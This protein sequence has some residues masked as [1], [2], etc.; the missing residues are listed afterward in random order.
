MYTTNFEQSYQPVI[1][2]KSTVIDRPPDEKP[3]DR[4]KILSRL[5]KAARLCNLLIKGKRVPGFHPG[6]DLSNKEKEGLKVGMTN[7]SFAFSNLFHWPRTIDFQVECLCDCKI[8]V[9]CL[10]AIGIHTLW[11]IVSSTGDDY[12]GGLSMAEHVFG[13]ERQ[14]HMLALVEKPTVES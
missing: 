1:T 6:R 9:G 7:L 13:A 12:Q 11:D 4:E 8:T 5:Q 2:V 3:M 14:Y 10:K